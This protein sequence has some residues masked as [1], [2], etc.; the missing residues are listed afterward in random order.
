MAKNNI[1]VFDGAIATDD[2]MQFNGF[3]CKPVVENCAGCDRAHE[4]EGKSYCQSYPLPETKWALG[5]CNF[6][7][8]IK[9]AAKAAT[10]VN[11][12]KASK[13]AAKGKK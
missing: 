3:T 6:A 7:T 1:N 5:R 12:L 10:K 8:H 2:G 4:F 9:N 11:P 13:R